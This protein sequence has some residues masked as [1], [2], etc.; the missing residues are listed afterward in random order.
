MGKSLSQF[1]FLEAFKGNVNHRT[2]R[3]ADKLGKAKRT[4][5]STYYVLSRCP[6]AM[7]PTI[8]EMHPEPNWSAKVR[9]QRYG[10]IFD[11]LAYSTLS[12]QCAWGAREAAEFLCSPAQSHRV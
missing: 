5:P 6:D 7:E 9:T 10:F 3:K 12:V 4:S 1:G 8:E 11:Q 2:G